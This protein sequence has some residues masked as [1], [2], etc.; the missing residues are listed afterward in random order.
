M[1]ASCL[2]MF[3]P[4]LFTWFSGNWITLGLGGIMLGMGLTLRLADFHLLTQTPRWVLT[5][6]F[7]QFTVMPFFGWLLGRVFDL[8]PFFAVGL[9]LVSCCPG[10][11]ASNV[12]VFLSRS[13]L[14]L[15]VTM[16]ALSTVS[17]THL[18]L[19]TS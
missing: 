7:L 10:G 6:L 13:N 16:T 4:P 1:S 9:I 8:S 17:Y 3:H 5:G 19:P 14:A 12:I 11:T 2:A 15:S 18:T